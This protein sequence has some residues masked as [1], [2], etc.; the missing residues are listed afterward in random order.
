MMRV[1]VGFVGVLRH[2]GPR[3]SERE[4]DCVRVDALICVG[5]LV[6]WERGSILGSGTSGDI[7]TKNCGRRFDRK[8]V[9]HGPCILIYPRPREICYSTQNYQGTHALNA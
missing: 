5:R 8:A 9:M 3:R 7:R 2:A 1:A 4:R 6:L